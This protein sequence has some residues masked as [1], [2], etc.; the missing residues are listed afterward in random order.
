MKKALFSSLG[1]AVVDARVLDLFAGT[2]SLGLEFLSR[3]AAHVVFVDRGA[4][5]ASLI[6]HNI[7][8]LARGVDVAGRTEIM[9][10]DVFEWVRR[11]AGKIEPFDLI[12][13]D[14][15]YPKSAEK[16]MA[17]NLLQLAELPSML[18]PNGWLIVGHSKRDP[19]EAPSWWQPGR[20]LAHGDCI[21][22]FYR[23]T[24]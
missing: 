19:I 20:R 16:S 13:A 3:G 1:E 10:A 18:R 8:L 15:P 9:R 24:A 7:A 5:A 21:A 22:S 17:W 23:R 14:P 6:E 4:E 11:N 12:I 2:G